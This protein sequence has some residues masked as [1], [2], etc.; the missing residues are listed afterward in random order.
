VVIDAISRQEGAVM[1]PSDVVADPKRL[2]KLGKDLESQ[3]DPHLTKAA[4]QIQGLR[5]VGHGLFTS[6]AYSYAVAFTEAVEFMEED[7]KTKRRNLQQIQ[8]RLCTNGAVWAT[9]EDKSR[10]TG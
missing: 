4:G 2:C 7:L 10:I 1:S 3:V 8:Q 5:G 6:T 9:A